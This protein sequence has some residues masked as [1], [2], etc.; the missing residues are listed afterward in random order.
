[1]RGLQQAN[2]PVPIRNALSSTG[3]GLTTVGDRIICVWKA[4]APDQELHFSIQ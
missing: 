2:G 1:M 4:Q 3:P